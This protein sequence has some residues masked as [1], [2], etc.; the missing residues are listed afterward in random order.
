MLTRTVDVSQVEMSLKELL[1]LVHGDTEIVLTEGS[2]PLARIVSI[3]VSESKTAKA[4]YEKKTPQPGL[5]LGAISI[6][7]DFDEPLPEKFW[8]G[9]A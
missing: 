7:D 2:T 3:A 1:S 6:S 4:S 8:L 9:E 5:H